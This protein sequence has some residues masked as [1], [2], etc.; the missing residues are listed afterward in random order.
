MEYIVCSN[1][2]FREKIKIYCQRC[3]SA[4][5]EPLTSWSKP[6][7]MIR[8]SGACGTHEGAERTSFILALQRRL[9]GIFFLPVATSWDST[10]K[11]KPDLSQQC[12]MEGQQDEYKMEDGKFQL[13]VERSFLLWGGWSNTGMRGERDCSISMLGDSMQP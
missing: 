5:P 1:T 7:L 8:G 13:D 10:E 4:Y 2:V 3:N 12:P 9:K 6:T 11:V